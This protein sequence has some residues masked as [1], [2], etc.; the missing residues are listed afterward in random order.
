MMLDFGLELRAWFAGFC[1]I[2]SQQVRCGPYGC[3][4]TW[5]IPWKYSFYF[6]PPLS[7]TQ[8]SGQELFVFE[9]SLRVCCPGINFST[10]W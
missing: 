6:V 1:A 9:D 4:A 3:A 5:I 8:P 7:I 2:Q 10:S